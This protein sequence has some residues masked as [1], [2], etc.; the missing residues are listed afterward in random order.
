MGLVDRLVNLNG[1]TNRGAGGAGAEGNGG[2]GRV[3]LRYADSFSEPSSTTGNPTVT[4]SGGYR[5][6][7]FLSTGSVTF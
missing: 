1:A 3:V 4:V 6:Y 2:S 7:E 5:Y